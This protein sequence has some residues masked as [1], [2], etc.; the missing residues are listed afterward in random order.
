MRDTDG[1]KISH[2]ALEQMRIRA[3][4]AVETG[5]SS[6]AVIAAL[7]LSRPRVYEWLAAYREGG[8]E[9]LR[10]KPIAGR[11]PKLDGKALQWIYTTVTTKNP[12]AVGFL[13]T[14]IWRCFLKGKKV[15]VRVH[16]NLGRQHSVSP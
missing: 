11:P 1:R 12:V 2:E 9:A 16:L 4:K 8:I 3:V 10:A 13:F 6:K 7:G 15:D 5:Q 14:P